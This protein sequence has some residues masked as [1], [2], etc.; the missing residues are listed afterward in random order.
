MWTVDTCFCCWFQV[1]QLASRLFSCTIYVV[2]FSRELLLA[3]GP[4]CMYPSTLPVLFSSSVLPNPTSSP[5]VLSFM[6][7]KTAFVCF[8]MCVCVYV[9][10][11]VWER[12]SDTHTEREKRS[13][14][15]NEDEA[16]K[17]GHYITGEGSAKNYFL[18][19]SLFFTLWA[20][21]TYGGHE[22]GNEKVK[23]D[24]SSCF[25]PSLCLP[26]GLWLA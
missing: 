18:F 15:W 24:V 7:Q 6:F 3:T 4:W 11:C 13:E 9:C 17:N 8:C 23:Y 10:M 12:E 22:D 19:F 1:S 20:A 26:R 16:R 25:P 5:P 2:F 14:C 21:G